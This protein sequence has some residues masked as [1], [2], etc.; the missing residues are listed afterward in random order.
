MTSMMLGAA[1]LGGAYFF[2][3][4]A[5]LARWHWVKV[6][7][8][9]VTTFAAFLGIATLLHW[10]SFNPS[11]ISFWAWATLYFTSPFLV[12]F[13]CLRTRPTYPCTAHPHHSLF[14]L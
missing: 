8:L 13:A 10:N 11:H 6:G 4:A 14:T 3:C 2:V 1:Y 9:P 7:F 12:L 5:T